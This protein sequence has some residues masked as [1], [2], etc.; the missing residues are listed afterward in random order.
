MYAPCET[1]FKT[2]KGHYALGAQMSI[3]V[4]KLEEEAL[5]LWM[6]VAPTAMTGGPNRGEV[7]GITLVVVPSD[8]NGRN[9]GGD[10]VGGGVIYNS[11]E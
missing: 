10:E 1:G 6:L 9:T 4:P 11:R 7:N 8:G 2:V 5:A 3:T